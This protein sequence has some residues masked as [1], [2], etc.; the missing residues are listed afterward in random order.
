[1]LDAGRPL[2]HRDAAY[3]PFEQECRADRDAAGQAS[4]GG[5]GFISDVVHRSEQVR[6]TQEQC[7]FP[8]DCFRWICAAARR[9]PSNFSQPAYRAE[10]VSL[11]SVETLVC[12]PKST[13]H[14]GF[15]EEEFAQAGITEGLVRI[16]VGI[17]DWRDLLVDFEQ[18]LDLI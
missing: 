17:E 1:M 10:C 2:A 9:P 8:A 11:G 5:A 4:E 12:H 3:E 16:S 15:T 14:S 18:A 7:D 13:T 6:I